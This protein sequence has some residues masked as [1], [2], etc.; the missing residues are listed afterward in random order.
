MLVKG[1]TG[2]NQMAW[3]VEWS[4]ALQSPVAIFNQ[5][6]VCGVVIEITL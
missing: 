3:L 2:H 4:S 5:L 1:A 6:N